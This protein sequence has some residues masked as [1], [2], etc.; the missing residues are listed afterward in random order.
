MAARQGLEKI[1]ALRAAG[2]LQ[3]RQVK[4]KQRI[5]VAATNGF[6][7]ERVRTLYEVERLSVREVAARLGMSF[8]RVYDLMRSHGLTRRHGSDQNYATYKTKPQFVLKLMLTHE[9]EV[10][11]IAG[12]M[13]YWA[14]G[15]KRGTTVDFTN[16]D[17]R[18]VVLF[19]TFLRRVCGIAESRVRVHLYAY[20]DQDIDHLKIFWSRVTKI[21]LQQFIEP[22]VHELTTRSTHRKMRWGLVHICYSDG[23]LLKAIL[24]WAERFAELWTGAGVANRSGL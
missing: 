21:P 16:S 11:R 6:D 18:A 14:E 4:Q 10:L 7:L 15:S 12:S 22:Y 1:A 23:R 20:A 24:Q 5:H 19:L 3:R 2:R 8:W 13:L 17:P 9:E